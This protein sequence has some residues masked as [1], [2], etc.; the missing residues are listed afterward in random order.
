M[1]EQDYLEL[2]ELQQIIQEGI[3]GAVP[4]QVRVRAEVAQIQQRTNGHCYIDLCQSDGSGI[5]AKM[6][7][8]IWRSLAGALLSRFADDSG[9]A[10]QAGMAVVFEGRVSYSEL[11]GVSLIVDDID[12]GATLGEAELQRRRTIERLEK[13]GLLELQKEFA[14]PRVPYRLAV[15]SAPDAAGYGDFRRHLLENEYGFA[16]DVTLFEATMQGDG[17]PASIIAALDRAAAAQ[18]PT[19]PLHP[20]GTG[21]VPPEVPAAKRPDLA[22]IPLHP[23]GT[24]GGPPETPCVATLRNSA[25]DRYH[26]GD[27]E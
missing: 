8:I 6:K 17:A 11:Y 1:F 12:V 10:L 3:E 5:V 13:E 9:S 27:A 21:G 15:I 16:F 23:Q 14:L 4:G 2:I 24:G 7:A 26:P 22:T 19:I 20:Q 25:G 18:Q